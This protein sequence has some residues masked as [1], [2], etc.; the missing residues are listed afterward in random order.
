[1][2]STSDVGAYFTWN[3]Y[4]DIDYGG[5]QLLQ[6]YVERKKPYVNVTVPLPHTCQE[7]LARK[8]VEVGI[9]IGHEDEVCSVVDGSF[10]AH[11]DCWRVT[12][13]ND[14]T[15]ENLQR[16]FD[17]P[18]ADFEIVNL[19]KSGGIFFE[20]IRYSF[21]IGFEEA[22]SSRKGYVFRESRLLAR[23]LDMKPLPAGTFLHLDEERLV[24]SFGREMNSV[25]FTLQSTISG[26]VVI[27]GHSV[28]PEGRFDVNNLVQAFKEETLDFVSEY[29]EGT[30]DPK[31]R[32]V[33][34]EEALDD[35]KR[36]LKDISKVKRR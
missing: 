8:P 32:I 34:F 15:D 28:P 14:C 23:Q 2:Q 24:M 19:M 26:Q 25:R 13:D 4:Q 5:L 27:T 31:E 7:L 33:D 11:G 36:L 12:I 10:S 6:P 29:F 18:L 30:D 35:M 17:S 21:N 22:A 20:G 3:S 16:Q 9:T 1:M